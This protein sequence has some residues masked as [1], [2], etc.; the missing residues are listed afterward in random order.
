MG[1]S[2]SGLHL[3]VH[4]LGVEKLFGKTSF[5]FRSYPCP[6]DKLMAENHGCI[7]G[8]VLEND[9]LSLGEF[10]KTLQDTEG[11]PGGKQALFE[12]SRSVPSP[13]ILKSSLTPF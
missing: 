7:L 9:V 3:P 10:S 5:R 12:P 13:K 11:D 6:V 4:R 8:T 2:H 1:Q